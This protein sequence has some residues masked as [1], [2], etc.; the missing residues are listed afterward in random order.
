ML[1]RGDLTVAISTGGQSPGFAKRL[2]QE[3]KSF[4]GPEYRAA[5]E[6]VGAQRRA[7]MHDCA[8]AEERRRRLEEILESACRDLFHKQR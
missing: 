1:R 4:L 6:S 8:N 2:R 5:L 7:L 3:L